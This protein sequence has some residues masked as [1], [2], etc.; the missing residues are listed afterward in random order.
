[1]VENSPVQG[2]LGELGG[3]RDFVDFLGDKIHPFLGA[4]VERHGLPVLGRVALR[5]GLVFRYSHSAVI[6]QQ[7]VDTLE[8]DR[9]GPVPEEILQIK[10]LAVAR[11]GGR[12][13]GQ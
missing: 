4:H 1:M 5:E 12:G 9:A 11:D 7:I 6:S 2:L 13:N 3:F 8:W 10:L